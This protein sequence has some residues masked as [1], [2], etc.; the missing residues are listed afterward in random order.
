MNS[1]M[2]TV[3]REKHSKDF[4]VKSVAIGLWIVS[5]FDCM[6]GGYPNILFFGIANDWVG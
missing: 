6:E 2:V 4:K 5:I 1:I 3:G